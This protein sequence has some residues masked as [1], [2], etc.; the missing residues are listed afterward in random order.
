VSIDCNPTCCLTGGV[1]GER[2]LIT[3]VA[4]PSTCL[5]SND[6]S[7]SMEVPSGTT[8]YWTDLMMEDAC[9]RT[10][11]AP[12]I[13]A[14]QLSNNDYCVGS[15]VL[16]VGVIVDTLVVNVESTPEGCVPNTG[17]ILLTSSSVNPFPISSCS[18]VS[19]PVGTSI[20]PPV[21]TETEC[22]AANIPAGSYNYEII[23]SAGCTWPGT[24]EVNTSTTHVPFVNE[25][26]HVSCVG[27]MDGSLSI[28]DQDGRVAFFFWFFFCKD[29]SH[30]KTASPGFF[31]RLLACC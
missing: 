17:Q 15:F 3:P 31:L 21:F 2:A 18:V 16:T 7:I 25:I 22:H 5:T 24:T 10:N 30:R 8:C 29:S 1:C 23:D 4:L 14:V 20:D 19:D 9:N 12:A 27:A 28:S 11:L 6:G 13:Y 26:V